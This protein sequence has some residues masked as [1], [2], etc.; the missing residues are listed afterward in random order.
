MGEGKMGHF[1]EKQHR[2]QKLQQPSCWSVPLRSAQVA[3]WIV[4]LAE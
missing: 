2:M 3:F 1:Q 4:D